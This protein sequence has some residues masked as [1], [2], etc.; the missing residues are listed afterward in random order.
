MG[1]NNAS[2]VVVMNR[3][4]ARILLALLLCGR[5]TSWN[6]SIYVVLRPIDMDPAELLL[7]EMGLFISIPN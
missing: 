2:T 5:V 6:T 1:E 3:H 7:F 4:K